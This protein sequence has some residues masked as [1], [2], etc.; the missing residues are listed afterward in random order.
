[1]R[2]QL[3]TLMMLLCLSHW[4][5][6][7]EKTPYTQTV[8]GKVLDMVSQ[9]PL[10]GASVSIPGTDPLIGTATD[11][12]GSF[13][14]EE[15]PTGRA[16]IQISYLGYESTS[17]REVPITSGKEVV[18]TIALQEN[19]EQMEEVVVQAGGD[20]R[21]AQ[22]EMATVSAR[23]FDM[24]AT[25]RFA[26]SRNDPARMAQNFAGVSG[27]NDS[28]NDIIIRGNS[29]TGVLWRLE[30]VDIPNPNHF[31]A[32]GT[33][34]GPVSI[35]NSNLLD[36]SDFITGAFPA[37]YG[38]A[39][40]G[41]F[42]LNLRKGNAYRRE[43]LFQMGFN[44][45]ELGTEGP[46]GGKNKASYL[47]NYRYSTIAM[48]QEVGFSAGTGDAVPY[49]QDFSMK[50][51]LPTEKTGRFSLFALG[52]KSNIDLLG[53]ESDSSTTDLYSEMSQNI[54][55]RA[56]MGVVGINHTL[57]YDPQTFAVITLSADHSFSGNRVDSLS[58]ENREA[59]PLYRNHYGLSKFRAQYEVHRK[60]DNKNNFRAGMNYDYLNFNLRDSLYQADENR[61]RDLRN[62][63]GNSGLFQSH[64]QWQHR[65]D[66]RF[67]ANIGIHYQNFMLNNAQ[68]L[69]PR[70]GLSFDQNERNTF[71]LGYGLHSQLQPLPVYF[72][73]SEGLNQD[74]IKTNKNLDFTK[75]H[76]FVAG[77]RYQLSPDIHLK[78]EIY[79]QHL[80]GIAIEEN[81]SS[82]SMLNAGAD[83][84]I[85]DVDSLTNRGRGRN[86]GLE[87]TLEKQ[88][89]GGSYFLLTT[90]LFDSK[91][92]GS[93]EEWRNTAFNSQY[94]LNGLL[95]KEWQIGSPNRILSL[96]FKITFAGGQYITPI[97]LERSIM[98]NQA[99][100]QEERAY[101]VKNPD[102]FRSDLKIN[103]RVNKKNLT[104]E[105]S[106]DIQ[107]LTNHQ[108]LFRQTYNPITESVVNSY[109][110]GIFPIPQ[111]RLTF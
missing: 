18:L 20:S 101:S 81:A 76:H 10:P 82:F 56:K 37:T 43:H 110:L 73:E 106:L 98:E 92:K 4:A 104:H 80:Y 89:S 3:I 12:D 22:N 8:R 7:Q 71:S 46:L 50:V 97:D 70:L 1:M 31:G 103:Y 66:Q 54:Y 64:L 57:Y 34:G 99:V 23:G 91:Y 47:L 21:E 77:H 44:G 96:D 63:S 78:S 68:Q 65:F 53:S 45:F 25:N 111:Y 86:Y 29:P 79:Y 75:S 107:N 16:T 11:L 2:Q 9:S 58:M 62:E 49:Y 90:S 39:T 48:M 14:L 26:G 69:E 51:D 93:D 32:M 6:A 40:A 105:W 108:N 36:K 27:A 38:N 41:V 55:N 13:E 83:F 52:G 24:E 30:G 17:L 67:K 33:T 85:P 61:F 42:D 95:G 74:P 59:V 100:Y 19:L 87:L 15:V 28:R 102:Y 35:L 60:V 84:G 109:Q 72:L 88:F 94:V 5:A